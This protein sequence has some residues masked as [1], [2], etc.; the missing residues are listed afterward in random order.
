MSRFQ[1]PIQPKAGSRPVVNLAGGEAFDRDPKTALASLVLTSLVQDTYYQSKDTQLGVMRGL[2][3]QLPVEFVAKAAIYARQEHGL[4]SISHFLAGEVAQLRTA[5]NRGTWGPAF[6]ER[7]VFR[8]DDMSEIASYWISEYGKGEKKTLPSAMKRGFAKVLANAKPDLLAKWNG[9]STRSLTLRQLAHLCHPKG[10]KDSAIYQLRAGLLKSADTHEVKLSKAG[11]DVEAKQQAWADLLARGKLKYLAALRN[12]RNIVE[13]A[14]DCVPALCEKL[15]S[16]K[17]V[18][19]SK[20]LPFNFM[21]AHQAVSEMSGPLAK[22][23]REALETGAD[24]SLSNVP[25]FPG[26]TLIALDD[27]G[28][29]SSAKVGGGN[30]SAAAYGSIFAAALMRAC[31]DADLM[32]F[33]DSARYVNVDAR[34]SLFTTARAIM[35]VSRPSGTNYHAPFMVA[36]RRY[37][38]ILILSDA[39]G[40][41]GGSLLPTVQTYERAWLTCPHVYTWDL[42]GSTTTMLP[43]PRIHALAGISDK[44]FDL[45]KALE[46]DPKAMVNAIERIVL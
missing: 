44:A 1:A 35:A 8:L 19:E 39:Q 38:R 9:A 30:I 18:R 16:E 34:G 46:E 17:D 32:L 45:M 11:G 22:M 7:V 26:E 29:M 27:S 23:A 6:F 25:S 31:K 41:M 4:R 36:N 14:P 42:V 13:T 3:R 28:S 37:Q 15:R 21:A 24:L 12:I 5:E 40:W 33:S 43:S 10:G 2:V 20:V